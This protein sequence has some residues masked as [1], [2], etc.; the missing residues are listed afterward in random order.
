MFDR[1]FGKKTSKADAKSSASDAVR[2]ES[3]NAD[4]LAV[5]KPTVGLCFNFMRGHCF[6][7]ESL[8]DIGLREVLKTL[9]ENDLRATFFCSAKICDA[10][11]DV[12]RRISADGHEIGALGYSDEVPTELTDEALTQ[13][14]LSCQRAFGKLGIRVKG[15]RSPKSNWDQRLM[16]VL[17]LNGYVYSAEHDHGHHPYW[18]KTSTKRI[19]RI[20][21]RTDDRGLRRSGNTYDDVVSKHFRVL[22][23]ALQQERFVSV[24]FHPWILAESME[25][26]EHWRLWLEQAMQSGARVGPLVD[27]LPAASSESAAN[28]PRR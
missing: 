17:P 3:R 15:F 22:R 7:S 9:S 8:S 2:D 11:P 4:E 20:P 5:R 12:I 28:G 10:A 18:L 13:L 24:C 26:L 27:A 19:V 6:D 14:A 1:F 25:R 21:I 16:S 23:R